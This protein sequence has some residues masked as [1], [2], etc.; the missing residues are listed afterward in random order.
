MNIPVKHLLGASIVSAL[1]WAGVIAI[2]VWI[3]GGLD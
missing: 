2:V 3:S 1:L